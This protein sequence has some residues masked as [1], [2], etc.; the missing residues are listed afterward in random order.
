ML[1]QVFDS[2]ADIGRIKGRANGTNDRQYRSFG[3]RVEMYGLPTTRH[4]LMLVMAFLKR[5]FSSPNEHAMKTV[6]YRGG[7]VTFRIPAD[8]REEYSDIEGGAFYRDHP[9]SGTL[10]LSIITATSP[11]EVQS[12]SAFDVLQGIANDLRKKGVEGTT[13]G[14]QDGNGVFKFEEAASEQGMRLTIFYWVVANALPPRHAR[15]ATFSYTIIAEQRNQSQIQHDLEMLDAEIEAAS[16][17]PQLGIV[18]K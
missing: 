13:K 8:W 2:I 7:V 9:H 10:R 14:R 18:A 4:L 11:S 12:R 1:C 15:I 17:S 3:S 6:V 16:F 5:F